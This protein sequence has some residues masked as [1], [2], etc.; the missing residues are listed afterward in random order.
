MI[1]RNHW[2]CLLI[3]LLANV[4]YAQNFSA[5]VR[6]KGIISDS[7]NSFWTYSNTNGLVSPHTR[8]I[9]KV[10]PLYE[11][12]FRNEDSLA[13]GGSFFYAYNA[14][15]E[16]DWAPNEYFVTYRKNKLEGIIG[17]KERERKYL[18]LSAVGGDILWSGNARPA[19]GLWVGTAEPIRL[20]RGISLEA[21]LAHYF[22]LD[23]RAV[24]QAYIHFKKVMVNFEVNPSS[25]LA[26]GVHHYA[27][28]G[29]VSET[30]GEQPSGLSALGNIFIGQGIEANPNNENPVNALG[31]HLASY[32]V[33]FTKRFPASRLE[34]YHQSLFE[35][36]PGA[37]LANFPDGVWGAFLKVDNRSILRG[38]LYEYVQ[39]T[40]RSGGDPS[41]GFDNYFNN[42]TYKSGWTHY[43][44]TI[45]MP[46]ITPR[47]DGM[48]ISNNVLKAHH[49]GIMGRYLNFTA[50]F[51]GSY[52]Q[53]F[54]LN[55][56][57]DSIDEEHLY[58]Y[59]NVRYNSD[60]YGTFGISIGYD[61]NSI[62][63]D[64]ISVGLEYSY[65]F[66]TRSGIRS[67]DCSY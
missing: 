13:I 1:K 7:L 17:A 27:Q 60:Y 35:D 53:D 23:D 63:D 65:S 2:L 3:I 25:T 66:K 8:L 4:S 44:N 45:G 18:G 52:V 15:R 36:L 61:N 5:D 56:N 20:L 67:C 12:E 64:A 19:P 16:D 47:G 11:Y 31:N 38:I 40:A 30:F 34:F 59:V 55:E 43:G 51:K 28:W 33:K 26:M 42:T 22:L 32:R 46:F 6:V 48:G 54:G 50:R 39:T 37:R 9:G 57:P 10:S 21:A 14:N 49:F 62:Q 58:T 24:D 41:L 29:G